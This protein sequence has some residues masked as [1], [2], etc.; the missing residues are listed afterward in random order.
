MQISATKILIKIRIMEIK[1]VRKHLVSG[2]APVANLPAIISTMGS[3]K[4]AIQIISEKAPALK[5]N[6]IMNLA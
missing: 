6:R 5:S 2:L 4:K 1:S 3:S